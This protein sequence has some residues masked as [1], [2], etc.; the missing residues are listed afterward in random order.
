M[1]VIN[2]SITEIKPYREHSHVISWTPLANGDSGSP[3]EM[4]GSSIRSVQFTGTFGAGG[5]IVFEGSNDGTN[6][7]TLT[8]PQGNAISKT[9]AGIE[10]ILELTRYVR[11]RVS[12]GDGTTSLTATLLV[13]RP[14]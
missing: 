9:S 6:Y 14:A 5:T 8:D 11:P 7:V 12:A 2:S 10:A 3:L 13:R 4:P 1:A